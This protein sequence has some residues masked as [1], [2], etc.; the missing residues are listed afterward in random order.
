[1]IDANNSEEKYYDRVVQIDS[2]NWIENLDS[3]NVEMHDDLLNDPCPKKDSLS[4]LR[5]LPGF[6]DGKMSSLSF[7]LYDQLNRSQDKL[8]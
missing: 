8:Q 5:T 2:W 3:E 4:L 7:S 6:S 1:M